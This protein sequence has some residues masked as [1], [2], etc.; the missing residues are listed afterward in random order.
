[1]VQEALLELV[2]DWRTLRASFH[3]R[4]LVAFCLRGRYQ[5]GT[6][7]FSVE[8]DCAGAAVAGVAAD[9][10]SRQSEI[11]TQNARQAA[12]QRRC[13]RHQSSIHTEGQGRLQVMWD[14]R[15][16]QHGL[17]LLHA[18]FERALNQCESGVATI[19]GG[20]AYVVDP[21]QN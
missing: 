16:G 13:N 10:R 14:W 17:A 12:S 1:M 9:F 15:S 8:E 5:A 3:R 4:D 6:D 21:G 11:I 18:S 20:G 2:E 19:V 7:R